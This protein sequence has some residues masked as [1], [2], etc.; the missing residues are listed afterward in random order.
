MLNLLESEKIYYH[1]IYYFLSDVD[2]KKIPIGE[3]NNI[4]PDEIELKKNITLSSPKSYYNGSKNI[5]LTKS[6]LKTLTRAYTIFIKHTPDLYCIDID[7]IDINHID[8][9]NEEVL[10]KFPWVLGNTKGIHVY[11]KILNVPNFTNQQNVYK[12]FKGDLIKKNNM[13]ENKQKALFNF[14]NNIP[15]IDFNDIK[16]IF[17]DNIFETLNKKSVVKKPKDKIIIE[18][19]NVN[20]NLEQS[21]LNLINCINKERADVFNKWISM[22]RLFLNVYGRQKGFLYWKIFSQ[23]SPKYSEPEWVNNGIIQQKYFSYFKDNNDDNES[24]LYKIACKDNPFLFYGYFPNYFLKHNNEFHNFIFNDGSISNYFLSI[25]DNLFLFHHS[26]LY[27]FNNIYWVQDSNRY[28]FL[29]NFIEKEFKDHLKSYSKSIFINNEEQHNQVKKLNKMIESLGF[30]SIRKN[31]IENILNKITNNDIVFDK[32]PYHFCFLNKLFDL[33]TDSFIVSEPHYYIKTTCK[34]NYEDS[35]NSKNIDVLNNLISQIFPDEEVK[36]FYLKNLSTGLFGQ[37]IENIF[38]CTGVGAN[39]KSFMHSLML[40]FLGNYGYKAQSS[41]LSESI[42]GGANPQIFNLNN[43]RFVLVQEPENNVKLKGC[44]IKELTGDDVIN[45]RDLYTSQCEVN[46][47]IS[48]FLEANKIPMIDNI[49]GGIKRR[50]RII[51]FNSQFLNKDDYEN[52]DFNDKNL[53]LADASCKSTDFKMTYSQA[54]FEILR[55]HFKL[56]IPDKFIISNPPQQCIHETTDF[57]E[58]SDTF[59]QWFSDTFK[60]TT[61]RVKPIKIKD[62]YKEHFTQSIYFNNLSKKQQNDLTEKEF[63]QTIKNNI[64]LKKFLKDDVEFNGERFRC[65][66]FVNHFFI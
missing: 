60:H 62:I 41:I 33:Q 12:N 43:K 50:L 47:K 6:E 51:P 58:S 13:W 42:K 44:C 18:P 27:Y 31:I 28:S 64:F 8:S 14:H 15:Q 30:Q 49:D 36:T 23:K 5:K 46:M 21:C 48:L 11:L 54:L 55:L 56:L 9:L 25:Y 10:K 40:Y 17:N 20:L 16:H 57:L 32:N 63:I 24:I 29:H 2:N 37:S 19:I 3:K 34:I 38:I 22:G 45:S 65:K 59:F 66:V 4:T 53:F 26:S 1:D 52:R 61:E 39:G 7:D 35:Y